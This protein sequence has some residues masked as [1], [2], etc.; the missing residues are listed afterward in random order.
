[1]EIRISSLS[2]RLAEVVEEAICNELTTSHALNIAVKG[3][4]WTDLKWFSFGLKSLTL[5]PSSTVP[6]IC[7][8]GLWVDERY[9]RSLIWSNGSRGAPN[10]LWNSSER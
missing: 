4:S 1:M 9:G 3:P 5:N 2:G 8:Q 7:A 6:V 10:R